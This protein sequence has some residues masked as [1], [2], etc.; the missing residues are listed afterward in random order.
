MYS[1]EYCP[2]DPG[3]KKWKGLPLQ[4]RQLWNA[5][6]RYKKHNQQKQTD[7][8]KFNAVWT[9][10]HV[11]MCIETNEMQHFLRMIF[12]LHYLALHVSDYHQSI[13]RSIIS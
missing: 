2:N 10:H 3:C 1:Y 12:I 7:T 8:F 5:Y 4:S 13:I 11:S 9:V 6:Q